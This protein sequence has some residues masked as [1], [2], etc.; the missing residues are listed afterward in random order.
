MRGQVF[1]IDGKKFFTF[2][3]ATSTAKAWRKPFVSWW[4]A[5]IPS[6]AE[7]Q[8]ADHNLLR[9]NYKVDF[10]LT[11]TAPT[12]YVHMLIPDRGEE[13]VCKTLDNFAERL[14]FKHWYFG[15]F[16]VGKEMDDKVTCIYDK[17]LRFDG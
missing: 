5:E 4:P 3:G 10:V 11:Y 8:E 14:I 6:F 2:G 16:H 7:V 17:V 13:I 12:K 15:H 9:H 1:E